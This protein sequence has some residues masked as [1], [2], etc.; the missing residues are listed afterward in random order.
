MCVCESVTHCGN[1]CPA[2]AWAC[3]SLLRTWTDVEYYVSVAL[4]Q[5]E[6]CRACSARQSQYRAH[7][8]L[9]VRC[10]VR[11]RSLFARLITTFRAIATAV[12][13]VQPV[14]RLMCAVP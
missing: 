13:P 11:I 4:V 6:L 2:R 3:S 10:D 9:G 12:T 5:H 7:P 8:R 14:T 1:V